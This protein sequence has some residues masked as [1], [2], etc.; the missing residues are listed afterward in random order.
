[1]LEEDKKNNE[2]LNKTANQDEMNNDIVN[3]QKEESAKKDDNKKDDEKKEEETKKEDENK[4]EEEKKEDK[5]KDNKEE[6][7]EKNN[8]EKNK[9]EKNNEEKK[10]ENNNTNVDINNKDEKDIKTNPNITNNNEPVIKDEEIVQPNLNEDLTKNND[11]NINNNNTGAGIIAEEKKLVPIE[12]NS[13]NNKNEEDINKNEFLSNEDF[14]EFTYILIKN[15]ESKK[16]T[17]EIARQKIMMA[18]T[19][20]KIE[21][22]RFIEQMSFNIMKAVHC[23]NK[24]SL[25]KVKKWIATLLKMCNDDQKKMTDNFL[26][27]F[28]SITLYNSEQELILSKKIKKCFLPKKEIIFQKLEP[29][30]NSY[31]SFSFLKQLIEEQGIDMK[32]DYAQY[33]FYELKKFEDPKVSLYDLK[34]QN[35]FNILDNNDNDSKMNT[36]SDIEITNEEYLQ[37]ITNFALQ[38]LNYLTVNK[39]DLRTVLGNIVQNLSGDDSSEKMEVVFIEPFVNKMKEIG[40]TLSSEVEIYCIFSRYKLS[41]D[42]EIISVNLLEKELENL[43]ESR[44]GNFNSGGNNINGIGSINNFGGVG[45]INDN[46]LKVME[47]VQEENEDNVSNS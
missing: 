15:F 44:F 24:E 33:L 27:L 41:D 21:K 46:T 18:T 34:V 36:E 20:D 14:T 42:Y 22:K 17:E 26:S 45:N 43:K 35:L 13:N 30:K 6:S 2:I 29:F 38:L 47:K 16:I 11:L 19:K 4:K 37:I 12:D 25:E 1:M 28:S 39:T 23:E 9:E 31:I 7:K 3:I 10:E 5:E 32:E 8:E 40:I